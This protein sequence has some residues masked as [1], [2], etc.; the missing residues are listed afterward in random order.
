MVNEG[1]GWFAEGRSATVDV[2]MT[3]VDPAAGA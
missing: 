3:V 1:V 2:G